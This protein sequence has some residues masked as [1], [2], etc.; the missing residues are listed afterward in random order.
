[1][2]GKKT[3]LKR[4]EKIAEHRCRRCLSFF[5]LQSLS[6]VCV[7]T[8]LPLSFYFFFERESDKRR[9][10]SFQR[11]NVRL[12]GHGDEQGAAAKEVPSSCCCAIRGNGADNQ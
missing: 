2:K 11:H 7:F 3:L 4:K 12:P 5:L 10:S 6:R 1:M 8:S 9:S